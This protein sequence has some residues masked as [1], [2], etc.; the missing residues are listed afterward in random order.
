MEP[1][2]KKH[3]RNYFLVKAY[4]HLWQ[5][6]KAI[7]AIKENASSSLQLSVLGKMTEEYEATDKQTLRAKNDLK[8]YWEGLLG[9]NTDFGHFYNPEIGTL[10]IAGRLASQFL[11]D[12]D[13]NVLGAI[14]SGPYG[15]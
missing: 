3:L 4:H 5:L 2:T 11:H 8:S 9:E 1:K 10:F 7:E 15:I 12:L 14:A 13:G 6:E